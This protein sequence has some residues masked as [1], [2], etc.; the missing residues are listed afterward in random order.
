[1]GKSRLADF[2]APFSSLVLSIISQIFSQKFV[3]FQ[4]KD[5]SFFPKKATMQENLFFY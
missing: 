2:P 3:N 5:F 4:E 1:M